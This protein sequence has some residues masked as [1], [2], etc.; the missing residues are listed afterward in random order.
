MILIIHCISHL[1]M[2]LSII[3]YYCIWWSSLNFHDLRHNSWWVQ[4]IEPCILHL[5][6]LDLSTKRFLQ[7]LRNLCENMQA[8]TAFVCT[9][10]FSTWVSC[11]P[12]FSTLG[13]DTGSSWMHGTNCGVY[14]STAELRDV[15]SAHLATGQAQKV[16]IYH[17]GMLN[18]Q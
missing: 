11:T 8:T 2:L 3:A 15:P 5:Y 14:N 7:A 13:Q 17:H 16:P 6:T 9:Q 1:Q 18:M 12:I 4:G 10:I